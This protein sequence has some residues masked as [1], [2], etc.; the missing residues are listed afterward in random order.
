MMEHGVRVR[1]GDSMSTQVPDL[2]RKALSEIILYN[3][4]ELK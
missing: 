4:G 1:V 3:Q 2:K